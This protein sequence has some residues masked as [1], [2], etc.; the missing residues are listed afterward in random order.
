MNWSNAASGGR[1][2]GH[3]VARNRLSLPGRDRSFDGLPLNTVVRAIRRSHLRLTLQRGR[4]CW[5][6]DRR[7]CDLVRRFRGF[8]IA[9]PEH[10][11]HAHGTENAKSA[12][13]SAKEGIPVRQCAQW[14]HARSHT[15][16]ETWSDKGG[17]G[18]GPASV[19]AFTGKLS[20]IPTQI[21]R[22]FIRNG[23]KLHG[24]P[25]ATISCR[26]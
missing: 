12:D 9:A 2:L 14:G 13:C 15:G 10:D 7:L 3:P 19:Y 6:L 5:R 16:P 23:R 24:E 25:C 1:W 20:R 18:T 4:C 8:L 22:F 26:Q 21:A 11:S 17:V